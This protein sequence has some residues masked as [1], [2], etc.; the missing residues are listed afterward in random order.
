MVPFFNLSQ[1]KSLQT[2]CSSTETKI[3]HEESICHEQKDKEKEERREGSE[4]RDAT[5]RVTKKASQAKEEDKTK[6]IRGRRRR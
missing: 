1:I 6:K 3:M 5:E 2:L 4:V